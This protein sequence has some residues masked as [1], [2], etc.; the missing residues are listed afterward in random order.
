[1]TKNGQALPSYHQVPEFSNVSLTKL[2][3][4]TRNLVTPDMNFNPICD[5]I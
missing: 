4:I 1:M 3:Y 2:L 5:W